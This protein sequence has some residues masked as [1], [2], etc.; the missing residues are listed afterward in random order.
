MQDKSMMCCYHRFWFSLNVCILQNSCEPS[1][2]GSTKSRVSLR[3]GFI[4]CYWYYSIYLLYPSKY[5]WALAGSSCA[6]SALEECFD[7]WEYAWAASPPERGDLGDVR[8]SDLP[9]AASAYRPSNG[10]PPC[11]SSSRVR[12]GTWLRMPF[13]SGNLP[14]LAYAPP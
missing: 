10:S 7:L 4:S 3:V 8:Q 1:L 13:K 5:S 2:A 14:P 9:P 6:S 11:L 12:R